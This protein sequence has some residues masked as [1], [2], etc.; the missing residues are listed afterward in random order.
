MV[1]PASHADSTQLSANSSPGVFVGRQREMAGLRTVLD[2]A[3]SGQGRLV[4]LTGEP[5]IGKT[6]V[7]QELAGAAESQGMRVF[8]G[9]CYEGLG[10]P[11]FWPWVQPIREYVRQADPETL[12]SEMGPGAADIAAIIPEVMAKLPG[13][14]EP[15]Q[16]D[17]DQARFR[18]FDSIATF[19]KNSAASKPLALV[20]DD[21]HWA[22]R[23]SLH[24]LEF[25]VKEMVTTRLLVIGT[26]RDLELTRQHPLEESLAQLV[27]E[28]VFHR[29]SL[30]GL[31]PEDTRRLI[32]DASQG[33]PAQGVVAAIHSHTEG[34]PFFLAEVI[35]L[36]TDSPEAQALETGD[37]SQLA[38]P[39]GVREVIGRRLNRLSDSCNQ[40]L[41]AASVAGREFE[42]ALLRELL[43]QSSEDQLLEAIDEALW[44]RLIGEVE[45]G[46]ERYQ[47]SH[48]L[49]QQTL[50]EELSVS[51]R[52]RL[53]ARIA[54]WLE[55]RHEHGASEHAAEMAYHFGE[56]ISV[57]EEGVGAE[58]LVHYSLLAGEQALASFAYAE[59][60]DF[61]ER[62]LAIKE[63]QLADEETAALLF[64]LGRAQIG[65]LKVDQLDE[66]VATLGRA[67]DYYAGV[68][69]IDR[70]VAV[71][72]FAGYEM[73]RHAGMRELIARALELV[74]SGTLQE[75]RLLSRYG[76]ALSDLGRE[77]H[78]E[79]QEVLDRALEIARREGDV[80]C[81][82]RT[83][84]S[85]ATIATSR[86][87]YSEGLDRSLEAISL[88]DQIHDPRT[89]VQARYHVV[90]VQTTNGDLEGAKRQASPMLEAAEKLR[91]RFWLVSAL[92]KNEIVSRLGGEWGSARELAERGLT[93]APEY[94]NLM[95][96]YAI[97]EYETGRQPEAAASLE[98]L[99]ANIRRT[100]DYGTTAMVIGVGARITGDISLLETA[101]SLAE[102]V[103]KT[104]TARLLDIGRAR[105]GLS[106]SAVMRGD[107]PAAEENY[108]AMESRKDTMIFWAIS[109]GRLLGLLSQ[110]MGKENQ[111]MEHFEDALAF[112]RKVG[113]RPE[114]AWTCHDYADALLRSK[115]SG[116]QVIS[117]LDESLDI[118]TEL[119]MRPLA[120]K[121]TVLQESASSSPVRRP[122]L[123]DG[124]T[125]RE[126]EV[127]RLVAAGKTDREIADELMIAP[128]T[129]TTHVGN[130][131]SKTSSSNRA[132]TAS[133]ATRQG[134]A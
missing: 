2:E 82:M 13:L 98:R 133:Y 21:L 71:V 113:Y 53:H 33:V 117:L 130:I 18:Y 122:S 104:P 95:A 42:F 86:L 119:G 85:M 124:L 14:E 48:A 28:P 32:E 10:A 49:V 80:A 92:W 127:L 128:R 91:D 27:R 45:G 56:A 75:G 74:Q 68:S 30:Q 51:R 17:P 15:P 8:W 23:S 52:S 97:L 62:A 37:V 1:E 105:T 50:V 110:T 58:K 43:P 93:I 101:Q 115:G 125:Q 96:D 44:A 25:L 19:L 9:R 84:A 35:R 126:A 132:E 5:G 59:A 47:F 66:A 94:T 29:Y 111:A 72:S 54:Q 40:M 39:T 65:T 131:L 112:C 114:L 79:V 76:Q 7:A 6:R 87:S 106:L 46:R 102:T 26:Y 83:L 20:L 11:P 69:D 60:L 73:S 67:F 103:L 108:A 89:E 116:P 4:M 109:A 31:D 38:I 22:D 118:S 88:A 41:S 81:E 107:A 123:P 34:N 63:N 57:I 90:T 120:E 77:N 134:L 100:I 121:V 55:T 12:R 61:F 129:A 16:L 36:L 24:L 70:A 64:G 78:D 3:I 99:R